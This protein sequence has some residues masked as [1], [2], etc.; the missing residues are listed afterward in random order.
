MLFSC[1]L[2]WLSSSWYICLTKDFPSCFSVTY[3]ISTSRKSF[4]LLSKFLNPLFLGT[5]VLV[6]HQSV[7][8]LVCFDHKMHCSRSTMTPVDKFVNTTLKWWRKVARG[9]LLWQKK[10]HATLNIP[11]VGLNWLSWQGLMTKEQE[12]QPITSFNKMCTSN[13]YYIWPPFRAKLI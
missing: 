8:Y 5:S 6:L 10:L 2:R 7:L 13:N 9:K 1:S 11:Q 12:F 3:N 4:P